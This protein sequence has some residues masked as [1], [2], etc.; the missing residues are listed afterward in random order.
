MNL[1]KTRVFQSSPPTCIFF[2]VNFWALIANFGV[3]NF[4]S[5]TILSRP[6][7]ILSSRVLKQNSITAS[8]MEL[9][10]AV[11]SATGAPPEFSEVL[12]SEADEP[13]RHNSLPSKV[14]DT[15]STF[16]HPSEALSIPP[17][18]VWEVDGQHPPELLDLNQHDDHLTN[19]G[20]DHAAETEAKPSDSQVHK[21]TGSAL[22]DDSKLV[23]DRE[24]DNHGTSSLLQQEPNDRSKGPTVAGNLAGATGDSDIDAS[25]HP[26]PLDHR[27][28]RSL[29]YEV[30]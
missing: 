18:S 13:V 22:Q 24:L 17:S 7:A 16:G 9:D 30:R 1:N 26:L 12:K 2:S 27:L 29:Y 5:P 8:V 20:V 4:D 11:A 3:L 23:N 10:A 21:P 28:I 14:P 25:A 19:V 15:D 6:Y